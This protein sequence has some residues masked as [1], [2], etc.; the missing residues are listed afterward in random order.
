M[1]TEYFEIKKETNWNNSFDDILSLLID[2]GEIVIPDNETLE[3]YVCDDGFFRVKGNIVLAYIRD[4]QFS[5][6]EKNK[7][8]NTTYKFHL[9]NCEHLRNFHRKNYLEKY[10]LRNPNFLGEKGDSNFNVN[11]IDG[12]KIISKGLQEELLVCKYCL[13]ESNFNNYQNLRGAEKDK[14]VREFDYKRFFDSEKVRI[15]DLW[16]LNLKSDKNTNI[17]VYPPNWKKLS[18]SI[19]KNNKF[20][21][22]NCGLDCSKHQYLLHVHH[23]NGKKNDNSK[24]NLKALCISC[25]SKEPGHSFMRNFHKDDVEECEALQNSF[26]FY[27]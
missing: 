23:I 4:Q 11:V 18:Q 13:S 24:K 7:Q 3:K 9:L 20:K 1:E 16:S 25:H 6:R 5:R 10:V 27:T 8:Y 15:Q 12:G 26:S 21:C 19:R 2:Q 14:F 17:N 22:T